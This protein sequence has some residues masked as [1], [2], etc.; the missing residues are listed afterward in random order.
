[1]NTGAEPLGVVVSGH[2]KH[3]STSG[4]LTKFSE[5]T[6]RRVDDLRQSWHLRRCRACQ[7]IRTWQTHL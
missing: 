3:R 6:Q 7:E 4:L 1:M 5:A 2:P